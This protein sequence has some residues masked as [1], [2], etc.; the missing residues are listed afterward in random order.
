MQGKNLVGDHLQDV[1]RRSHR[2]ALLPAS[3]VN[4]PERV[5]SRPNT[6]IVLTRAL[7]G[8]D[9]RFVEHVCL[10]I[11]FW[12]MVTHVVALL[13]LLVY[14]AQFHWAIPLVL[15]AGTTPGVLIREPQLSRKVPG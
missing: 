2:G 3:T 10:S 4:A 6:T 12:T 5:S 9:Q 15:A 14:L 8:T 13:S 1:L 11:G 7:R